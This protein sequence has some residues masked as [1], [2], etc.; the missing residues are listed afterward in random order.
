MAFISIATIEL[1]MIAGMG[2]AAYAGVNGNPTQIGGYWATFG[3]LMVFWLLFNVMLCCC[4]KKVSLAIAVIDA[5]ADFMVATFRLS[6]VSLGY[7]ILSGIYLAFWLVSAISV[8]SMNT[9]EAD[10]DSYT[11]KKITFDSLYI[12]MLI[13]ICVVWLWIVSFLLD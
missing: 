11:G 5:T 4:W 12:G 13:F 2:A 9:I 8:V 6:F 3:V 10:P 7:S 1:V